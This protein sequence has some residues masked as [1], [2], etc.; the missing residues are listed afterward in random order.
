MR[1]MEGG[2]IGLPALPLCLGLWCGVPT[3]SKAWEEEA[4]SKICG[5]HPLYIPQGG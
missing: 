5:E 1:G 2:F 3:H 4:L